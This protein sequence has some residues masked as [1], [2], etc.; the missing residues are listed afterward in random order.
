MSILLTLT[1]LEAYGPAE[2]FGDAST[3]VEVADRH[4]RRDIRPAVVTEDA[5]GARGARTR[6]E[7]QL[8]RP[9]LHLAGEPLVEGC[10]DAIAHPICRLAEPDKKDRRRADDD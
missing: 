7:I 4:E 6:Q 1:S 2:E 8:K 10:N 5:A 3:P 9:E